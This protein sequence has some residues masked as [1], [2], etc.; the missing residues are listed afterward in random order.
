ME[1]VA[2]LI[3]RTNQRLGC[4][5]NPEHL[6]L[7]RVAGIRPRQSATGPLTG[8]GLSDDPLLY[9]G[10]GR[11]ELELSLLFDVSLGGSSVIS[12]DIRDL[13]APLWRLAENAE[14]DD[15]GRP[16]I[17]R[18]I[19]GKAW[20][21]PGVIV[22]VAE[23]LEHFTPAGVPQRSW[24]R[25][26][27]WR[28]EE[29]PVRPA[30]APRPRLPAPP[31]ETF[32]GLETGVRIHPRLG[33]GGAGIAALPPEFAVGE[34]L[35]TA[36]DLIT[37]AVDETPAAARLFA[38]C[39]RIGDMAGAALEELAGLVVE[40][41]D[42]PAVGAIRGFF[43][44]V[45]ATSRGVLVA[46][47]HRVVTTATAAAAQIRTTLAA[48]GRQVQRVTTPIREAL[49]GIVAR[50]D[51][52][53]RPLARALA[54][55]AA[56]IAQAVRA[57]ATRVMARAMPY[58]EAGRGAVL[59]ALDRGGEIID[60]VAAHAA[61]SVREVMADVGRGLAEFRQQ[62]RTSP[63]AGV[64]AALGRIG[65][66]LDALWAAG[67]RRTARLL[68]AILP[69]LTRTI[70]N[71]ME[72]GEAMAAVAGQRTRA[73]VNGAI[74]A[75]R[76]A[77]AAPRATR[78]EALATAGATLHASLEA[79]EFSAPPA[80][81]QA[82]AAA[83]AALAPVL[84][85]GPELPAATPTTEGTTEVEEAV[86]GAEETAA[87]MEEPTPAPAAIPPAAVTAALD[88][89][90]AAL[91]EVDAA[92]EQATVQLTQRALV[93]TA[94]P[95]EEAAPAGAEVALPPADLPGSRTVAAGERLDQLAYQYYGEAAYWRVLAAANGVTDP[96]RLP[97]GLLLQVPPMTGGAS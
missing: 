68:H 54:R 35:I 32:P 69:K 76:T 15:E 36:A 66:A 42:S 91:V 7:R 13:T 93:T 17:V 29:T 5:L 33:G 73:A 48:A 56:V 75:L 14:L 16:P 79:A 25:L 26:R 96:L 43:A 81:W 38:A 52:N 21:I 92:E 34:A 27:M 80:A 82:V 9:T 2:F 72:A 67:Q 55:S 51:A 19:W 65:P 70:Q 41:G 22:T 88:A 11:T 47:K 50:V 62:G 85:A 87:A 74:D 3:E 94:P 46:A 28:T 63:L 39:R 83:Q 95:A 6:L 58:V 61:A 8:V 90:A 23:R 77:L 49:A 18:F 24:L 86:S 53:V 37:A 78:R 20:N 44:D 31:S 1:R 45:A 64:A 60:T 89:L 71:V 97:A 84:E 40:A 57:K 10:G 59:A 12:E 4:L 30:A